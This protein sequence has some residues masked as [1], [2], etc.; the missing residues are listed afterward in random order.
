LFAYEVTGGGV[1]IAAASFE[2]LDGNSGTAAAIA[3]AAL[4]GTDLLLLSDVDD[5]TT[6]DAADFAFI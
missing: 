3:D 1:M 6:L 2:A 4:K 5:V